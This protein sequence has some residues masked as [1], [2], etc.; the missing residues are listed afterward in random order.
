MNRTYWNNSHTNKI[1]SDQGKKDFEFYFHD[2][3]NFDKN[4]EYLSTDQKIRLTAKSNTV[5]FLISSGRNKVQ[6]KRRKR[7]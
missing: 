3:F 7:I 1:N 5:T 4:F 6:N 2:Q